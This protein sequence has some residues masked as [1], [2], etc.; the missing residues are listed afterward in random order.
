MQVNNFVLRQNRRAQK[1]QKKK[2]WKYYFF[3]A[4]SKVFTFWKIWERKPHKHTNHKQMFFSFQYSLYINIYHILDI[5]C[6]K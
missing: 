3:P 1:L 2:I 6:T 5:K 4:P